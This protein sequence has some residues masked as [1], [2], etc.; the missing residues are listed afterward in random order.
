MVPRLI[1][2]AALL[3][4]VLAG[5]STAASAKPATLGGETNLRKAPGIKSEVVTLMPKGATVEVGDCDAGWCTVS[6]NG[7][8]GYAIARNL[9]LAPRRTAAVRRPPPDYPV[10]EDDGSDDG[11]PVVYEYGPPP[12]YVAGPPVYYG[13]YGYPR[14]WRWGGYRHHHWRHW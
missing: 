1:A 9:G 2:V 5:L 11:P 4:A 13:Y 12:P 7:Q 3:G 8:N 10:Y 6:W 14:A